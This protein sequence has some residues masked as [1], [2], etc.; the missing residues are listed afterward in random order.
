MLVA[1]LPRPTRDRRRARGFAKTRP[2]LSLSGRIHAK[3]SSDGEKSGYFFDGV[4][5]TVGSKLVQEGEIRETRTALSLKCLRHA[6]SPGLSEETAPGS[7]GGG[8]K[9]SLRRSSGAEGRRAT[10]RP[11]GHGC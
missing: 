10:A 6:Q 1:P 2:Q 8:A 9:K 4:L 3:G 11:G 5:V 7:N